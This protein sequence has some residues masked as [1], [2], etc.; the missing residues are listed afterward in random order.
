M[1]RESVDNCV[2][3]RRLTDLHEARLKNKRN[4]SSQLFRGSSSSIDFNRTGAGHD[5]RK[6]NEQGTLK[7]E[8]FLDTLNLNQTISR[9]NGLEE[10]LKAVKSLL[11]F[12]KESNNFTLMT[13][14]TSSNIDKI[15]I[16]VT[17]TSILFKEHKRRSLLS[18]QSEKIIPVIK[19]IGA[20]TVK[21]NLIPVKNP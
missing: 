6:N 1:E 10:S 14:P 8:G 2:R 3:E 19:P 12:K 21:L 4:R 15:K 13:K 11:S 7:N 5:T 16:H 20:P 9:T 17:G 18:S